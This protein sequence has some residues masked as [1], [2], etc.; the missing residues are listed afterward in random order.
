M[1]IVFDPTSVA[2]SSSASRSITGI[3]YFDFGAVC[4]PAERWSDFA[5]V[6]TGWWLEALHRM[7]KGIDREVELFFMDGPYHIVATRL[8]GNEVK[9]RCVER[10]R[11]ELVRHEEVVQLP[12]LREQVRNVTKEIAATCTRA[13]MQSSDLEKLKSQLP[14]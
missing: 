2:Q 5:V 9:L 8:T 3:V 14:N 12:E 4:F 1:R 13:G 6:I 7:E 11:T 10:G